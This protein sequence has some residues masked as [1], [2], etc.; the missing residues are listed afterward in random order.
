[1]ESMKSVEG[2]KIKRFL[3]YWCLLTVDELLAAFISI[4]LEVLEKEQSEV[5]K[6]DVISV[7]TLAQF[8]SDNW[9]GIMWVFGSEGEINCLFFIWPQAYIISVH[10]YL[11]NAAASGFILYP[12]VTD[13]IAYLFL[14]IQC[15]IN[16]IF[17][18][19]GV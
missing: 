13:S 2:E 16:Y 8:Q 1:M 19:H 17:C 9:F 15:N 4:K 10:A 18:C 11:I 6:K 14:K 5:K 3:P 7:L 12:Y